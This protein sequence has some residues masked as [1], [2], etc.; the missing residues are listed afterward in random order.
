MNNFNSNFLH[1]IQSQDK[2][3]FEFFDTLEQNQFNIR[4]P[5]PVEEYYVVKEKCIAKVSEQQC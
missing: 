4:L 3:K 5:P 1:A 2:Q